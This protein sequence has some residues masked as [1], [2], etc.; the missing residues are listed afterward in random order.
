MST[1]F[2]EFEDFPYDELDQLSQSQSTG[3]EYDPEVDGASGSNYSG[4]QVG[5]HICHDNW[6]SWA[7]TINQKF[8]TRT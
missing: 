3:S 1:I 2:S 7:V 8:Q 6:L 4:S 5:F